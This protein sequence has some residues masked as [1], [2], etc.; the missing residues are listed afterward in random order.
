MRPQEIVSIFVDM[1]ASSHV[2]SYP[3]LD[4]WFNKG[5]YIESLTQSE[6][7]RTGKMCLTFVLRYYNTSTSNDKP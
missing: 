3:E 7:A 6:S 5:M 4:E 1:S 2:R